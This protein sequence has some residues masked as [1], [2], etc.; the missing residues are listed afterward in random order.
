MKT[1]V[2][3]FSAEGHTKK[4]AEEI[5]QNLKAD[6]Y[7][8]TPERPY[9]IDDLDWTDPD[10]RCSREND[11]I[12]LRDIELKNPE[13]PNW[14]EYERIIIGYPIWWGIAAWPVNSFV[15]TQDWTDKTILPFCTSHSSS[16]GDSDLL[17]KDDANA[18]DWQEGI[19]FFQD[20]TPAK[21]K[22][23]TDTL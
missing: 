6:I 2:V 22:T 16:L 18:G 20:A 7:E 3:Y 12:A 1:L 4:I 23:W 10:S 8:I 19:R 21:I 9:S 13:V 14:H 15:K 5:A 11:D 17:L